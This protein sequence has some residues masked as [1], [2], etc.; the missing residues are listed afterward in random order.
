[1]NHNGVCRAAPISSKC[2]FYFSCAVNN[3]IR[4][5]SSMQLHH[6]FWQH[7]SNFL[8]NKYIQNSPVQKL[9]HIVNFM[10]GSLIITVQVWRSYEAQTNK[11]K[12]S[13]IINES[14][15]CLSG[16]PYFARVCQHAYYPSCAVNTLLR[17]AS[18]VSMNQPPQQSGGYGP[19]KTSHVLSF[20]L[21][22][23]IRYVPANIE[24]LTKIRQM[25]CNQLYFCHLL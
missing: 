1:M 3:L 25:N 15:R 13:S 2:A 21:Y 10:T 19:N 20:L 16:S 24:N 7:C 4:I 6:L 5:P 12:F 23:W 22:I 18:L 14:Q 17:I 11:N 9:G 8:T